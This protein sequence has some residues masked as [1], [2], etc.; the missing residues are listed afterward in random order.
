MKN[1]SRPSSGQVRSPARAQGLLRQDRAG[2]EDDP[3][4]GA[5]E[6][7]RPVQQAP[8]E[9]QEA[10]KRGA[11]ADERKLGMAPDRA[12]GRAGRVDEDGIKA[13]SAKSSRRPGGPAREA[14]AGEVGAQA[15][16]TRRGGV[17]GRDLGAR[18]R[19]LHGL[20]TGRG[21]EVEDSLAEHGARRRRAARRP[22]P[23]TQNA[24][25]A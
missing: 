20:A 21:A 13:P 3:P 2:A 19:H 12:G 1:P 24:P 14:R 11:V 10:G 25:S 15:R 7:E 22:R 23:C 4:A 5:H 17:H 16:K 6:R 9:I 18:G 8:L